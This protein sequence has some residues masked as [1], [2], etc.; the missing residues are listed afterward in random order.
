[1]D[2]FLTCLNCGSTD[3]MPVVRMQQGGN[4][5]LSAPTANWAGAKCCKC[6]SFHDDV[7]ISPFLSSTHFR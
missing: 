2:D 3:F 1:M 4:H 6:G 7:Y 5:S